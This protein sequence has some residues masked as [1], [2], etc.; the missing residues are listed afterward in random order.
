MTPATTQQHTI[1]LSALTPDG[2]SAAL[3][4]RVAVA[5]C[6]AD[7]EGTWDEWAESDQDS[8][9]RRADAAIRTIARALAGQVTC[10]ARDPE[11]GFGL[12]GGSGGYESVVNDAT[13][14]DCPECL[15]AASER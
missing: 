13:I 4:D 10:H 1:D 15:A 2:L 7:H 9:R 8:F 14:S 6:E 3:R 5:I 12:C 11:T